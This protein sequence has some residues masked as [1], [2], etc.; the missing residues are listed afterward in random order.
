[1]QEGER[2]RR[3]L[4]ATMHG[5]PWY[6]PAVTR[7]I[8]GIDAAGAAAH[9]INGAHSI[10]ELVLHMTAWAN[11]VRRRLEGGQHGEPSEGDWPPVTR[12]TE[13]AWRAALEGL[14]AAHDELAKALVATKD[15]DLARQVA[16]GQVDAM[17]A[18]VTLY[19]TSI[20]ILQHDTY[21]AGQIALLKRALNR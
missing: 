19:Q 7:I 6:G 8:D 10:W 21:H 16:G 15:A 17:G 4:D 1:M 3:E 5:D 13:A 14:R 12:T 2:L 18:P 9:P 20:G 11:E